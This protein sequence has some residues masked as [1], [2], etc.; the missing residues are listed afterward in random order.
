MIALLSATSVLYYQYKVNGSEKTV[1]KEDK[2]SN[3]INEGVYKTITSYEEFKSNIER[4]ENVFIV[5]GQTGCH[6]CE[7]FQPVLKST[8]QEYGFEVLYV[9]LKAL[10]D[11]DYSAL[12]NSGL[13]IPG[14]CTDTKQDRDISESF[15]TPLSL[16]VRNGES[17]DCL[18]G[19]MQKDLFVTKLKEKGYVE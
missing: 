4:D 12:R 14:S 2:N 10:G 11:E 1:S 16:F 17:Y 3:P 18:R 9:D 5:F 15:N 8:S 19:F 13:K 7:L 6:F